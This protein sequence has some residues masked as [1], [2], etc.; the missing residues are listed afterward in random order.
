MD[1]Q[2]FGAFLAT[3]RKE[4]GL[5]QR[6]LAER[7]GVTDKAVSK[8]ERGLGF[9]DIKTVEPLADALGISILELMQSQRVPEQVSAEEATQAVHQV[10]DRAIHQRKIGR[11]N[12]LIGCLAL[13]LAVL[14]VFLID[15]MQLFA[16][17]MVCLPKMCGLTG[18][19][20][21]ISAWR[22]RVRSRPFKA[23]LISGI[24]L[25]LI[26]LGKWLLLFFAMMLGGPV[27]T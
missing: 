8:W 15:E 19:F 9:P 24:L 11:R 3:V 1:N 4:R 12:V 22:R 2:K 13:L 14:T 27:T 5:S 7:L 26:P 6:Q 10:I 18:A 25:L 23:L 17:V 20:L 16:F 21:I